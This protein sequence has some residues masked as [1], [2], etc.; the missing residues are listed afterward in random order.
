MVSFSID[1]QSV[2]SNRI[3]EIGA[4][5]A[6]SEWLLRNGSTFKCGHSDI[7]FEDY[8]KLPSI[9]QFKITEIYSIDSSLMNHGFEHLK[10][11]DSLRKFYIANNIFITNTALQK[12]NYVKN[13]LNELHIIDCPFITDDGVSLLT[14][15]RY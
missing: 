15:L 11:L 8:N 6:C 5:A 1:S 7:V 9:K 10:D 14:D 12:L 13:S 3:K 2:D 4:N